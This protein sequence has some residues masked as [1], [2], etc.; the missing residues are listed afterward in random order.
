MQMIGKFLR[1]Q[2][3]EEEIRIQLQLILSARNSRIQPGKRIGCGRFK[4]FGT[5]SYLIGPKWGFDQ[6]EKIAMDSI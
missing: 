6:E 2:P 5:H 3:R 4:V 1:E